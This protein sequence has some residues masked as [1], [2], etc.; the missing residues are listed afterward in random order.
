M[1]AGSLVVRSP[2]ILHPGH[3]SEEM[4]G[5][6][7]PQHPCLLLIP[8]L[9]AGHWTWLCHGRCHFLM[10]SQLVPVV[11]KYHFCSDPITVLLSDQ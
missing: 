3:L 8:S 7:F 2:R 6:S 11:S 4:M 5:R 9:S 10:T 1:R